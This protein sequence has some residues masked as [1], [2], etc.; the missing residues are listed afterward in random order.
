VLVAVSVMPLMRAFMETDFIWRL[1]FC[2]LMIF[3][4]GFM[5]GF[6]FPTGMRLTEQVSDSLTPWFWGINGALGVVASALAM[7]ISI[8]AGLP[9]T[10]LA[11]AVC[12]GLL[13]WPV[14][15]L[16]RQNQRAV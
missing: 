16:F 8:G 10:I 2:L 14:L 9:M 12:Y 7:V 1:S 15:I 5:M 11:G 6:A 3:P 4:A 13:A